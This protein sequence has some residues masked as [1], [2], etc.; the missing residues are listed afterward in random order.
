[1]SSYLKPTAPTRLLWSIFGTCLSICWLKFKLSQQLYFF[2]FPCVVFYLFYLVYSSAALTVVNNTNF[3]LA[4]LIKVYLILKSKRQSQASCDP[5]HFIS[6]HHGVLH[7]K[8]E[9]SC[10]K[11]QV[12]SGYQLR[13]PASTD[14]CLLSE[15]TGWK[16]MSPSVRLCDRKR[17]DTVGQLPLFNTRPTP[18]AKDPCVSFFRTRVQS[19][20]QRKRSVDHTQRV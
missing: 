15:R 1:M 9:T 19:L 10:W 2:H 12:K 13:K 4:E 14:L 8:L 16:Q 5:P 11:F 18:G 7:L 3:P 17:R 6:C 20:P